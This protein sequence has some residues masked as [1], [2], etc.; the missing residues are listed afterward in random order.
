MNIKFDPNNTIIRLCITG[1][2]LEENGN[3][4]EARSMF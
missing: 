1:M 2:G 3:V 4:D